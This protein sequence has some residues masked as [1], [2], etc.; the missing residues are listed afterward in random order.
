MAR[1]SCLLQV[2]DA[3]RGSITVLIWTRAKR[4]AERRHE[5]FPSV[6]PILLAQEMS[7][8]PKDSKL[9]KADLGARMRSLREARGLTQAKL[10]TAL[11]L[12]QSNVSAMERGD[13]GLTI[14]QAVK[15][16]KIFHV[17][18]DE[19]LTGVRARPSPPDHRRS[20]RRFLRR[21]EKLETL[22][23]RD[24]QALLRNLDMFLK[25]AGID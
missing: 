18:V 24:R 20:N 1:A 16:A 5:L 7:R 19:L 25:G 17:T 11:G 4:S 6:I 13:R 10:A 21:L 9:S 12:T 14:Y 23:K 15:V 3:A 22:S 8:P 2:G